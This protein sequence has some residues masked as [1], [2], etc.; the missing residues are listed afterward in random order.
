MST[1]THSA[2]AAAIEFPVSRHRLDVSMEEIASRGISIDVLD[3][4]P[5]TYLF[6]IEETIAER[7]DW[8][9]VTPDDIRRQFRLGAIDL[10]WK[11]SMVRE[12]PDAPEGRFWPLMITWPRTE[13]GDRNVDDKDEALQPAAPSG[14]FD[15]RT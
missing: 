6:L 14:S 5:L 9:L 8:R 11:G 10:Y 13:G 1:N 12:M 7:R 2:V 15:Q 3:A 4:G